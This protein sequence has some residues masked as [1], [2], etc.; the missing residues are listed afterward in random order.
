MPI[1]LHEK[2]APVGELGIWEI[3]EDEGF[4]RDQLQLNAQEVRQIDKM[5]GRRRI[6][7]LAG[8]YLLHRMSGR[9]VR[10]AILK[11]E[12]GKPHLEKSEWDISISHSR[13]MAAV[14]AAPGKVGVDIQYFVEKITRIA[15]KFTTEA[16]RQRFPRG[17]ELVY[18][19]L[20]WG[21][22]EALY[23]A[24]GRRQLDFLKHL[25]ID[26]FEIQRSGGT[27]TG[28]I[29]KEDFHEEYELFYQFYPSYF[30]VFAR[31]LST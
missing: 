1:F 12:F 24:Y 23:K 14:Y 6:E 29:V 21:A 16:D 4:F 2:I 7:W 25:F 20:Y 26:F 3:I 5:R 13:D 15:P 11:D 18:L 31:L 30:L 9:E 27:F 8:R 10:G 19:H 28:R 22:K 17:Q